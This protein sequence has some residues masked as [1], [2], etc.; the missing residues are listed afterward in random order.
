MPFGGWRTAFSPL[1]EYR[2]PQPRTT[3]HPAGGSQS[4]RLRR[5]FSFYFFFTGHCG[6]VVSVYTAF[7]SSSEIAGDA[8]CLCALHSALT[9]PCRCGSA[10]KAHTGTAIPLPGVSEAKAAEDAQV[11]MN[12]RPTVPVGMSTIWSVPYGPPARRWSA[13]GTALRPDKERTCKASLGQAEVA[14]FHVHDGGLVLAPGGQVVL[15]GKKGAA[16]LEVVAVLPSGEDPVVLLL[17]ALALLV[18]Q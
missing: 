11:L 8:F 18:Q 12:F 13:T 17:P 14:W 2:T 9:P 15:D 5:T 10:A 3:G 16:A 4:R 6:S 7:S 1:P